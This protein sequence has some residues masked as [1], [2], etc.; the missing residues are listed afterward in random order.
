MAVRFRNLFVDDTKDIFAAICSPPP[1]DLIAR[2]TSSFY[3]WHTTIFRQPTHP[4]S[5]S[6]SKF[7]VT[8]DVIRQLGKIKFTTDRPPG[9]IP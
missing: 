3:R 6:I 7:I 8:D 5:M 4:H 1:S 2:S 9:A